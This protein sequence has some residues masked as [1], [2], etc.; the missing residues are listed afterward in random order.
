MNRVLWC[1]L[2]VGCGLSEERYLELRDFEECRLF[3]P[4]CAGDYQT[5]EACMGDT[6][7]GAQNSSGLPYQRDSARDCIDALRSLC[8]VLGLDYEVP[9][10]CDRVYSD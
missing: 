5:F 3:G 9:D 2:F 10:P 7:L 8:P 4:D 1:C 6:S